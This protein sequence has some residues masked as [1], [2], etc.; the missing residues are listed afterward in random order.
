MEKQ[1]RTRKRL[2]TP[3]P[4]V[5]PFRRCSCEDAGSGEDALGQTIFSL[6][7][8]MRSKILSITAVVCLAATTQVLNAQGTGRAPRTT[9]RTGSA[10]GGAAG[11]A[12][13]GAESNPSGQHSA[14]DLEDMRSQ[15][16]ELREISDLQP[17]THIA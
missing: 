13:E 8:C 9:P 6:R 16:G 15:A 14:Q 1:T 2:T 3:L 12:P 4:V 17:F 7:R 10:R 11:L 5:R